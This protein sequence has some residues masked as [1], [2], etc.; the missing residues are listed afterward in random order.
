MKYKHAYDIPLPTTTEEA[1]DAYNELIKHF[2]NGEELAFETAYRDEQMVQM[3]R[4]SADLPNGNINLY[5]FLWSNGSGH[6]KAIDCFN[7]INWYA[8]DAKRVADAINYFAKI[9]KQ[10]GGEQ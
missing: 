9:I 6:E 4:V 7:I 2:G 8:D 5:H 3:L 10:K 1:N